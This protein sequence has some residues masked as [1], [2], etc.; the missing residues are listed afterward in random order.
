M[1]ERDEIIIIE[2]TMGNV[3][4]ATPVIQPTVNTYIVYQLDGTSD[5][6]WGRF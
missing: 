2:L 6:K 3:S 1:E 4:T 5:S